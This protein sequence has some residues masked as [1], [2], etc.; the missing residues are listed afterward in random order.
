M[1]VRELLTILGFNSD[2]KAVR[3]YDQALKMVLN[4]TKMLAIG[5]IALGTSLLKGAGEIEQVTIAF[6]TMLRSEEKAGQLMEEITTFAAHTPFKLVDL[7]Q[8]SKQLLAF[9]FGMEEI[10]PTMTNLGNIAAGIGRDKL[11]SLILAFGKIRT[12]GKATLR[13]LNIMMMAG[14]PILD[15]LANKFGIT[16]EE[17]SEMISRGQVGFED[18]NEALLGLST[19]SGLFA[20][21]MEKQSHTFL[22]V[23]TN[24]GDTI[25][26][27][28]NSIGK[29]LL[30]NA[31][32]LAKAFLDFLRANQEII[33]ANLVKYFQGVIKFVAFLFLVIK[34]LYERGIKPLLDGFTGLTGGGI[35]LIA[36]LVGISGVVGPVVRSFMNLLSIV[37]NLVGKVVNL[38]SEMAIGESIM[39]NIAFGFETMSS[40]IDFVAGVIDGFAPAF[41]QIIRIIGILYKIWV[42]VW[43]KIQEIMQEIFDILAPIFEELNEIFGDL[44]EVLGDIFEDLAPI[45]TTVLKGM[46]TAIGTLLKVLLLAF[47]FL[48]GLGREVGELLSAPIPQQF[49]DMSEEELRAA[50]APEDVIRRVERRRQLHEMYSSLTPEEMPSTIM[51][52]IEMAPTTQLTLEN[53]GITINPP[54]DMTEQQ[55]QDLADQTKETVRRT[56]GDILREMYTNAPATD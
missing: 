44:F 20:N 39:G 13:E 34:G 18:V 26:N 37:G 51:G 41:I 25:T 56:M 5:T 42:P 17:V 19:G 45:V 11:P 12:R 24:I 50:N 16:K 38:F 9:G 14:V 47:D 46:A 35:D 29:E 10:I 36:V 6:E 1:I 15:A 33:K 22:G 28:N 48:I 30:G 43:R 2:E 53:I 31:T 27:L 32:D 4:T 7:I 40:A 21:L 52:S 23:L 54:R 8:S 3:G 49:Q 55:K